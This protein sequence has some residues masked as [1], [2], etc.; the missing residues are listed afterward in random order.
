MLASDVARVQDRID[1]LQRGERLRTN[2]AV[3][4]GDDANTEL[5]GRAVARSR[6]AALRDRET[7]ILLNPRYLLSSPRPSLCIDL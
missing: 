7:P 5:R 4:V 6:G 2:Q 1:A 3:R